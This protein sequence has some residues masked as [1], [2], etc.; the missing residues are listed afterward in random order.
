M[1]SQ[2]RIALTA[3]AAALILGLVL[4]VSGSTEAIFNGRPLSERTRAMGLGEVGENLLRA[5]LE[6]EFGS[7]DAPHLPSSWTKSA[8][9]DQRLALT[10]LGFGATPNLPEGRK[11]YQLQCLHCHGWSGGGDTPTARILRPRPRD[12]SLGMVKFKSTPGQAAPLRRDLEAVLRMGIP[13]TAMGSFGALPDPQIE[14]LLDYTQYLLIRGAV[15]TRVAAGLKQLGILQLDR[16]PLEIE[17]HVLDTVRLALESVAST[18]RGAPELA[19]SLKIYLPGSTAEAIERGRQL[20]ASSKAGCSTCHGL[21]ARGRGPATWEE[22]LGGYI[23]R[24]IW[25]QTV[26]PLD[27]NYGQFHGGNRAEDL[28]RRI[29]LGIGGT[30]MPTHVVNL[31]PQE[32]SDL[33]YYVLD[34]AGGYRHE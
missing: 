11:I 29:A 30:P 28:Y 13:S 6:H 2:D 26:R 25:G 9:E 1:S 5:T 16:D 4:M 12:F 34:L 32:I 14:A 10:T 33:V 31:E 21:D 3:V 20:F 19:A 18:W 23:L 27:L 17:G 7:Y 22:S 15:E 8:L 24:D